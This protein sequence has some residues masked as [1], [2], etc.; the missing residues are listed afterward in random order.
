M[1]YPGP[2]QQ[3][4][5]GNISTKR[6]NKPMSTNV[7]S[8]VTTRREIL[9]STGYLAGAGLLAGWLP[10]NLTA[11]IQSAG[12]AQTPQSQ[13]DQVAQMR[14]QMSAVPLQT[15]KL[16][17]NLTMLFGPGGNMV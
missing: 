14:A 13:T 5:P 17:D 11:A 8:S 2:T 1:N 10:R 15:L 9:K 4:G 16:F 6:A 7:V 3:A 12:G